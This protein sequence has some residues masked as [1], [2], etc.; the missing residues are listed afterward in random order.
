MSTN[1]T[2][3]EFRIAL[4]SGEPNPIQEWFNDLWCK[5]TVV[6]TNVYRENGGEFLY[7]IR[8]GYDIKWMFFYDN[9]TS[10]IFCEY[11]KFWS[12]LYKNFNLQYE[13]VKIVSQ[14]L[15]ENVLNDPSIT[16]YSD[17]N[18]FVLTLERALR[19]V[20]NKASKR[21]YNPH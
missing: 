4:I 7:Y 3:R 14:L 1:P 13:D 11:D 6:E 12:I 18:T 8:D 5:L 21:I 20:T 9:S 19:R 2:I 17:E 10:E 15:L 16:T